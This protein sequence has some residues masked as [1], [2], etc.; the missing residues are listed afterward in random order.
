M[1]VEKENVHAVEPDAIHLGSGAQIEHGPEADK[2][3]GAG[4]AFAD[5]TGPHGVVQLG[6]VV[7]AMIAHGMSCGF[8][9]LGLLCTQVMIV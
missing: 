2:G 9:R 7:V 3:F 8:E 1:R 6:I 5:E 4:A